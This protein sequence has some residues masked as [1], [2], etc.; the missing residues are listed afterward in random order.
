MNS[1]TSS[2]EA[3][4]YLRRFAAVCALAFALLASFNAVMDPFALFGAP[5]IA[6][7]NAAK[8]VLSRH[9]REY[10]A[11]AVVRERPTAVIL[12][13]SRA[14]LGLDP[15]HPAWKEH[16]VYN[17]ALPSGRIDEAFAYLRHAHAA[18]GVKH[19]V[20]AIDFLMFNALHRVEPDFRPERLADAPWGGRPARAHDLAMALFS[21]D[22]LD[23][24]WETLRQQ[25]D[26]DALPLLPDGRRDTRNH[27]E[28]IARR[29]GHRAAFLSSERAS[30]AADDGWGSFVWRLPDGTQPGIETF[31]ALLAYARREGITVDVL[32]SPVH[33]RRLEILH[34]LGLWEEFEAWKRA[35]V[36]ARSQ[37]DTQA[38]V[39]DFTG[40]SMVTTE[41]VPPAGDTTTR[42]RHYWESSHYR[43]E[44]GDLVLDRVLG[45]AQ[46]DGFG[47]A[48]D[49]RNV[50][51]ALPRLRESRAQWARTNPGEIEELAR[52]VAD[53]R[54]ERN[55]VR[56]RHGMGAGL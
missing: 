38:V 20:L 1:S 31:A 5:R 52:L 47:V 27:P 28:R 37:D 36:A 11:H 56:S 55:R 23:A 4:H 44:M 13:S 49:R 14:E 41:P 40:F 32:T 24:A 35:L 16:P 54:D 18:G 45:G 9:V 22:A 12:G 21:L 42:M 48:L 10:K 46:A 6:G 33:A 15:A 19:A 50:D 2:S 17:L 39:W 43:R 53:T 29:G 3:A 7:V 8:P 25:D 51:T 26:P 30:L 34:Q